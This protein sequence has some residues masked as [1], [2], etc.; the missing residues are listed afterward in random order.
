MLIFLKLIDKVMKEKGTQIMQHFL[1][2]HEVE[3]CLKTKKFDTE[4]VDYLCEE[5]SNFS[6]LYH[7]YSNFVV[8]LI[9]RQQASS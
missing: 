4:K 8:S 5:S 9:Y 6:Y 7:T 3:R 2:T 1:H